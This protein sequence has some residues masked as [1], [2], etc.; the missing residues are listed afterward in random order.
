M[1]LYFLAD[2][3]EPSKIKAIL[4]TIQ[5]QPLASKK[6]CM[7]KI[8]LCEVYMKRIKEAVVYHNDIIRFGVILNIFTF[9]CKSWFVLT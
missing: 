2:S 3:N 8:I 5:V 7:P 9:V 4:N 1:S 6:K